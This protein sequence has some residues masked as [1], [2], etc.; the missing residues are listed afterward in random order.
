M[1]RSQ[2]LFDE[3]MFPNGKTKA[4]T[5]SYDDGTIH[6][7]RLIDIMNRY[8]IKG[9]FNLNSGFFGMERKNQ[10]VFFPGLDISVINKDEINEL[11]DGHEI[12]G[13]GL[14]HA[15]PVNTGSA[16]YMY[17]TIT[18]RA[19]LEQIT[20]KHVRGYAYPFGM[21]SNDVKE[22]LRLAG[23]QY[24]RVVTTTGNF[25]LPDDFLEWK[26]TCHHN[27]KKL[28]EYAEDFC[29]DT[30]FS[31]MKKL[32]YVWGHSYEFEGENNWEV[33]ENLCSYMQEH[34][35]KIWFATNIE[36][37]DYVT[38]YRRLEYNAE[39]SRIYN[40]SAIPV[41]IQRDGTSVT[42]QPLET[43]TL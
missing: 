23:Y 5:L 4:F 20:G 40:P 26:G 34:G 16:A 29:A 3:M 43:V 12:A 18:D 10:M 21:Y 6:D 31:I 24:A 1:Q 28:M 11:Y 19:N 33:I 36:I 8:H 22:I 37:F 41:T 39:G 14:N 38:A 17:D 13:H 2:A 25:D 42:V 30:G 32:F 27:D 7:R 9:T 15:S 35:E